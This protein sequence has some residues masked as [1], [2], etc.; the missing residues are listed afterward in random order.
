M[1]HTRTAMKGQ[2]HQPEH[3][4]RGHQGGGVTD[5]PKPDIGSMFGGPG[6][7]E[8]FVFGEESGE[9][10]NT[11]YGECC[12]EHG[13][14]GDRDA[15][16]EIAHVAHVLLTAHGVNDR[17]S[18]EEEQGFE[19]SMGENVEDTSSECTHTQ[20]EEHVSKLGDGGVS[21]HALDVVLHQ[22][23]GGGDDGC[24]CADNSHR[25]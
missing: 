18:A 23:D 20:G 22:A 14:V 6:L 9:W 10:R 25:L 12:D 4:K 7:P 24:Q 1:A 16:M 8:D 2:V 5:G 21:Q 19:T 17:A 11:R 3:V 15:A 13:P